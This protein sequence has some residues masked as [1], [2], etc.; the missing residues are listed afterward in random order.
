MLKL[1]I[2]VNL[3]VVVLTCLT[4]FA[5]DADMEKIRARHEVQRARMDACGCP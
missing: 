5:I 1:L 2:A 4:L 3:V